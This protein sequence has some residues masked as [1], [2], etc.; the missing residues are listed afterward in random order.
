MAA[1]VVICPACGARNK[2]T[3]EYCARCGETLQGETIRVGAEEFFDETGDR[4]EPTPSAAPGESSLPA[5]LVLSVGIVLLAAN[6]VAC[7]RFAS[8]AP[9]TPPPDPGVFAALGGGQPSAPPPAPAVAGPGA[10]EFAEGY[11]L[12]SQKRAADA[13]PLLTQAATAAPDKAEFQQALATAYW[14]KGSRAE[15]LSFFQRAATLD[16][17]RYRSDYAHALDG[18]GRTEDAVREYESVLAQDAGNANVQESLGRLYARNGNFAAAAPLLEKAAALANDPVLL[19]DLAY[20]LERSNDAAKATEVYR[21][22]VALAPDAAVS[23]SRLAESLVVQGKADEALSVLKEGVTRAP[24]A[25]LLQRQLGSV[26]ERSGN[27]SDAAKA[28][29]QYIQLAPN[30]ADAKELATRADNLDGIVAQRQQ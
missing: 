18:A 29:R 28:Y 22:V 2:P 5:W 16:P 11:R 20:A 6:T 7:L 15:A 4:E 3:W 27:L 26:L 12:L 10:K 14:E 23:R 19:Q 1:Q 8:E 25:P 30:A 21:K 17:A 13:I 9:P 24:Q